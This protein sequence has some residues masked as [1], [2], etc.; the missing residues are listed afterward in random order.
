TYISFGYL[1]IKKIINQEKIK[2]ELFLITILIGYHLLI[3]LIGPS[4][5]FLVMIIPYFIILIA[6]TFLGFFDFLQTKKIYRYLFYFLLILF[7]SYEGFFMYQT[8]NAKTPIT[9]SLWVY[10]KLKN[11]SSNWG[12]NELEN[13]LSKLLDNKKPTVILTLPERL[14][15]IQEF[16]DKDSRKNKNN[17]SESIL[18]IYDPRINNVAKFWLYD[19]R[20][21]YDGWPFISVD[22]YISVQKIMPDYFTNNLKIN[23]YY[24]IA[25]T[26]NTFTA[27]NTQNS[28]NAL[29]FEDKLKQKNI[30]IIK[31]INDKNKKVVFRIYNF[32]QE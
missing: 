25:S 16:R 2:N 30:P 1:L 3:F 11:E 15:F 28:E 12:Y 13:Y 27:G 7:V 21:Y 19:R 22:E 5:R 18:I 20:Y 26:P 10:S 17:R 23:K 31:E 4:E 8:T 24:Y 6:Y 14:N 9:D 32:N 29:T